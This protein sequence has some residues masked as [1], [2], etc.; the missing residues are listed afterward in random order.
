MPRAKI[1]KT[2]TTK[3]TTRSQVNK[4]DDGA[5]MDFEHFIA[6]KPQTNRVKGWWAMTLVV[7][8]FIL[9]AVWFFM[10]QAAS[11]QKEVKIKAVYLEN[12]QVYYAKVV[13]ED[14]LNIF[15]DEVYYV[16][17]REQVIP[18][19]EEDGEPQVV[20]NLVLIKRGQEAH[21]PT[22]WLQING[23]TV[24]AIEEMGPDSAVLKEI[25]RVNNQ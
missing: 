9:A 7:L 22:G 10:S 24:V 21:N 19:V 11:V 16:E 8:I 18:S 3:K 5:L 6:Q 20:I 13:K 2:S 4:N 1:T 25:N 17:E 23:A 12:G 15:L 14:A